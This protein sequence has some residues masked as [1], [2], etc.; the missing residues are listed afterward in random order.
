MRLQQ[1][2][3]AAE[4]GDVVGPL[5]DLVEGREQF[6]H[7]RHEPLVPR[8]RAVRRCRR[9]THDSGATALGV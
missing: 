4:E 2:G 5:G 3:E 8:V 6:V 7:C 1:L 9:G